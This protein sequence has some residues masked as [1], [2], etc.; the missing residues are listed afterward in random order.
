MIAT[1]AEMHNSRFELRRELGRGGM[2]AVYE[3]FDLERN[4][5]VAL[6]MLHRCDAEV[7]LSLKQEFRSLSE[8]A[9]PRL[10]AMYELLG[11]GEKWF[12][13]MEFVRDGRTLL[14]YLRAEG[15]AAG[16]ASMTALAGV[17]TL[18]E[19]DAMT[20]LASADLPAERG[21]QATS[22]LDRPMPGSDGSDGSA[23]T[24][25]VLDPSSDASYL[26]FESAPPAA[27]RERRALPAISEARA[28]G[29][30]EAF[31]Q[32]AEGVRALHTLGKL[33]RDL[34]P[35][36]IL[37]RGDGSL[38]ILDFG[39]AIARP[40]HRRRATREASWTETQTSSDSIISGTIA[41]MSPEQTLGL[42]LTE[43]SDWFAVGTMLFEALAGELP[44]AGEPLQIFR[45]KRH[46]QAPV[47]VVP[48]GVGQDMPPTMERLVRLCNALLEREPSARP[49]GRE[50]LDLLGAVPV[51]GWGA[52]AALP[53][54][55]SVPE[56]DA[57]F[58]GREPLLEQMQAAFAASRQ[59]VVVVALHGRSGSGKTALMQQFLTTLAGWDEVRIF[60]GRCYEQESMPYKTLDGVADEVASWL[61]TLER[62]EQRALT[63]PDA[64][65]L[66]K[67]LPVFLR[68]AA[69]AEAPTEATLDLTELRHRGFAAFGELL[70]R[71]GERYAPVLCIDDL[72]W[73][74][75]DG[76]AM[77]EAA[78]GGAARG[79][80]LLTYRDEYLETSAA[81]RAIAALETRVPT[82]ERREIPVRPLDR[83]ES[84]DLLL[85]LLPEG[86]AGVP[87]ER[88]DGLLAQAQGNPFFLSELARHWSGGEAAGSSLDEVLW[89]RIGRLPP[90]EL[91]LL[92]TIAVSGQPL[93][94]RDAQK[95]SGLD[96]LPLP[97]LTSL[98]MHRLVQSSGLSPASEVQPYHDRIRETVLAH[99]GPERRRDRHVSLAVCLEEAGD[100]TPD[101]LAVHFELGGRP[102]QASG[103]YEAAADAAI[104]ALAFSRAESSY[105]KAAELTANPAA[106][107]RV[108]ER[109]VHLY[110]DLARFRDAYATGRA[111]LA[112]MGLAIPA[113]FAPPALALDLLRNW[114]LM[115]GRSVTELATLP[116]AADPGHI[117]R[118]QMLAA[119]GKAAY[120]IRPEL[121]IA[122]M[123]KL[124]NGCLRQGN[125]P[126]AAIG[127]MAMGAIFLGG[128]VGRYGVGY[129]YGRASLDLVERYD[130]KRIRA[131]VN[132]V[133]GYFGTSW[134]RTA[135]DAEAL[136]R[137]AREAGV[138][139]GDLF[140]VG[141]ACCATVM[142]QWMRGARLDE[143]E[144]RSAEALEV[145][146]RYGLKEPRIAIEAVRRSVAIM[147]GDTPTGD[148][149][150]ETLKP[151]EFG[152]RHLGH[153]AVLLEMQRHYL[154]GR[155]PEAL[156]AARRSAGFLG[157]SRGMLHSAEH[158]LYLA[159]TRLAAAREGSAVARALA[160]AATRR[161]VARFDRWAAGAPANFAAKAA[162][163]RG[164]WQSLSGQPSRALQTLRHAEDTALRYDSP[165]IA[166]LANQLAATCAARQRNFAEAE[167][168]LRG[169]AAGYEAWG[170]KA[171]ASNL[172]SRGFVPAQLAV[173]SKRQ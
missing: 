157:D 31:R 161:T 106:R 111:A 143:L 141:C 82:V 61:V 45:A 3:A 162:L 127:Y 8:V 171:Y 66:A 160:L 140:H 14:E 59:R 24:V 135:T 20:A 62:P 137:V 98:R 68:V 65:A 169:A 124:V 149:A 96:G 22:D 12:F 84:L 85:H 91:Q 73:G 113:N 139:T 125:T 54:A 151:E 76:V 119:V 29:L 136:W 50:V 37:V 117:A 90:A 67:I 108:A 39:L 49:D 52:D 30:L 15:S 100:A 120:Q 144:L 9:H 27:A 88:L 150:A 7:I 123:V 102:E 42:P 133:V 23:P 43:A 79:L 48:G 114:R 33:H 155:L 21:P 13:T 77:L 158:F 126:D 71:V 152:S 78:L 148:T 130:A 146:N 34:K 55:A 58:V 60:R 105:R 138:A 109:L 47:L 51:A 165:H 167:R 107:V 164:E 5:L 112:E 103:Y 40:I 28:A 86:G 121:C 145:V 2:G 97:V 56:E 41:Y 19:P 168:L 17:G 38:V 99:L 101:T 122:V 81:L 95:A 163:L 173:R 26:A 44:F 11:E 104:Q 89:G 74:D 110:T 25:T 18:P 36:N 72:Q 64:S 94:L 131:E 92:E 80:V 153:Y 115:R 147:R 93:R 46:G 63:P 142:S 116:P 132:F 4:E 154:Y 134:R 32:L 118:T 16:K 35:A 1:M 10:I 172:R 6:K 69:I 156:A 170:A 57:A 128:I 83:E 53:T 87:P 75:T 129:E 159:L 166:A 70:R